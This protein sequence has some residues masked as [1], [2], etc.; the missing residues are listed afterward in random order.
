MSVLSSKC[1]ISFYVPGLFPAAMKKTDDSAPSS[2][3][4]IHAWSTQK[5]NFENFFLKPQHTTTMADLAAIVRF[6]E[7]SERISRKLLCTVSSI[8]M[9]TLIIRHL[10]SPNGLFN[11]NSIGNANGN[12][13]GQETVYVTVTAPATTVDVAV[14]SALIQ[15]AASVDIQAFWKTLDLQPINPAASTDTATDITATS[16]I[17][18][19]YTESVQVAPA[20]PTSSI[21]GYG[22]PYHFSELVGTTILQSSNV[23]SVTPA[24]ITSTP[25]VQAAPV[26]TEANQHSTSDGTI[27]LTLTSTVHLTR[28]IV[29]VRNGT[30]TSARSFTG[31]GPGGWNATGTTLQTLRGG[32][33]GSGVSALSN[34]AHQTGV[35][36]AVANGLATG[37]TYGVSSSSG[38]VY[39][40]KGKRQVGSIVVATIDG[41]AVSWTNIYDGGAAATPIPSPPS[42]AEPP[43]V[44]GTLDIVPILSSYVD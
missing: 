25:T 28:T 14:K 17:F 29:E 9:I 26:S 4:P 11:S 2:P 15:S 22:Q 18:I 12:N 31:I 43:L 44:P 8:L 1:C 38:Q 34:Q 19:T 42:K 10:R 3:S 6:L 24:S 40:M 20:A 30:A 37:Y 32:L 39:R 5:P 41:V 21:A 36:S 27:F 13:C 16:T 23:P 7:I 35:V 33:T